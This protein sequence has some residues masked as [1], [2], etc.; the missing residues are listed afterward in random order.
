MSG[1]ESANAASCLCW[2][3]G[4]QRVC[5]Q[6]MAQVE[7]RFVEIGAVRIAGFHETG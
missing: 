1:G 3:G 4:A 5:E 7:G 6:L 2:A